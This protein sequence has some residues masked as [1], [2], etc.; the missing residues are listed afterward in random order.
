MAVTSS[1]RAGMPFGNRSS[2][3]PDGT[4][5]ARAVSRLAAAADRMDDR[6]LSQR[7][8]VAGVTPRAGA[9]A[10]AWA[11]APRASTTVL[12][13]VVSLIVGRAAANN[14]AEVKR[15][16]ASYPAEV[17]RVINGL[18]TSIPNGR[19]GRLVGSAPYFITSDLHRCVR[20]AADWPAAQNTT[21]LYETALEFYGARGW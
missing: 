6:R 18:P 15:V 11:T 20:G 12:T 1:A 14:T 17:E 13:P 21:G 4:A 8:L 2:I 3:D 7:P 10:E 9:A 16:I 5:L 19:V